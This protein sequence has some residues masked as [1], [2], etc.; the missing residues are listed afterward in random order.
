MDMSNAVMLAT[1]RNQTI[2]EAPRGNERMYK[3]DKPHLYKTVSHGASAVW[4]EQAYFAA[5][6]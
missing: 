3:H 2:T 5:V 4:T 6:H 1:N